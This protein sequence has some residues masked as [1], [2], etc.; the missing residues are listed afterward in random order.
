MLKPASLTVNLRSTEIKLDFGAVRS[1]ERSL[2]VSF[3]NFLILTFLTARPTARNL[4]IFFG[5]LFEILLKPD[6]Q[7]SINLYFPF[8]FCFSCFLHLW[9]ILRI[10]VNFFAFP[11]DLEMKQKSQLY[12]KVLTYWIELIGRALSLI[13]LDLLRWLLGSSHNAS[14]V[15]AWRGNGSSH[16]G[17]FLGDLIS[18]A[19]FPRFSPIP[20][21]KLRSLANVAEMTQLKR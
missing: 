20:T 16:V 11:N 14:L 12:M 15:V 18:L 10:H 9:R 17:T 19:L 4:N 13:Y 3:P 8:N 2:L 1:M 5:T 21:E 7:C 6:G